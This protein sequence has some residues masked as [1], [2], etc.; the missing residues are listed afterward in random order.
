MRDLGE[1]NRFT[2]YEHLKS[3]AA[4]PPDTLRVD[5]KNLREYYVLNCCGVIFTTNK[6][7]SLFIPPDDRRIYVAW[8]DLTKENF[9]AEYWK[10]LWGW[11]GDGGDRHV[12]AYLAEADISDFDAKAPHPRRPCSTRSSRSTRHQRTTSWPMSSTG[13]G[14]LTP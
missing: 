2:F 11:Y 5:E 10:T 1:V 4:A 7:D 13:L 6:K 9:T 8:S 12:A 14:I 3:F